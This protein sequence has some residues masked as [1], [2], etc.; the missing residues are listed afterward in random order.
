MISKKKK[1]MLE[2]EAK[3]KQQKIDKKR[4]KFAKE[5]GLEYN[6]KQYVTST[7][8]SVEYDYVP[9]QVYRRETPH[10][11]SLETT[12][13]IVLDKQDKMVYTGTLIKGI[14]TMHKS[15]AV[16]IINREEAESISKMRRG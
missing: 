2:R 8:R 6:G 7:K 10:I 9:T 1:L 11:P 12:G 14:A 3:L 13:K 5:Y 16:P 15:N 4:Q